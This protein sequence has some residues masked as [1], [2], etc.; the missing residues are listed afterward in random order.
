MILYLDLET[1]SEIPLKLGVHKYAEGVHAKVIVCAWAIDDGEVVV[2]D[3]LTGPR[4]SEAFR[5][6]W[7]AAD[8]IVAHN[9][10]FDRIMLKVE[11]FET[12]IERWRCTMAQAM[13]NSL[14]GSLDKLCVIMKVP[15]AQA[16][17]SGGKNLINL[18]CIPR[19]REDGTIYFFDGITHPTEWAE[20]LRYAGNDVE[21][22]RV[23]HKKLPRHNYRG[24]ELATW[25][26]DQKINDRGIS[27]D[28]DLSRAAIC[29]ADAEQKRLRA[30][31]ADA[32][33]GMLDSTTQRKEFLEHC[34][35]MYGVQL[36]DLQAGTLE[37]RLED[38]EIPEPVKELL[39]IRLMASKT[40]S[41][42]Y[43]TLT[44]AVCAD[45]RLHGL[46][47]FCGASRTGRWAGRLFQPQNLPRTPKHLSKQMDFVIDSI[48]D[49]TVDL[50]FEN[51]MEA[52]GAAT[53]GALCAAPGKKLVV[54][55][56]SNIEG[57]ML[58]WLA[59]EQWKLRAFG[60]FDEGT[61]HDLYVLAYSA[62]FGVH[63]DA[64]VEDEAA[65]GKMRLIGKVQELACQFGGA[66]GAFVSM[67]QAYGITVYDTP[68]PPPFAKG[69]CISKKEVLSFV[70]AWRR[71]NA[72]IVSFW[73]DLENAMI[74]AIQSPGVTIPVGRLHVRRDGPWLRI[75]LPSGRFLCYP[76]PEYS[77]Q[78][79]VC[80]S[81]GGMKLQVVG[82]D[83][84][85]PVLEECPKCKGRGW[86][87]DIVISYMGMHQYTRQWVRIHTFG[88]KVCENV[89]SAPSRD[90]LRDGMLDAEA[91]GYSVCLSVHDELI[92][93]TPDTDE[94]TAEGLAAIMTR[95]RAWCAGLPLAAKGYEALR[96]RK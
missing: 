69:V 51:T 1:R 33:A 8:E 5:Q 14:P 94:W 20:F 36:P 67:G 26:L 87:M 28:A 18:F 64:V 78:R 55:D 17:L 66:Y 15:V 43:K 25:H 50:F 79:V 12:D 95:P 45:G 92:T 35:G 44:N 81:C 85:G 53:R 90:V 91:E 58:A 96:Y 59:G 73:G 40:S 84:S 23:L 62:A 65:G 38:P 60:E 39:R 27:V 3:W 30:R 32:T 88:G 93:E 46:L 72:A 13:S 31:T 34:L 48:K 7:K 57:R 89:T 74:T 86:N 63:P 76:H 77:Q 22:C 2:E 80:R 75:R 9:A 19:K 54:A 41:T 42:K 61:G 83:E 68:E 82:E 52:L 10:Q 70:S 37:R 47:A 56:L 29:A 16:K 4:A 49:N 71:A 24:V 21:A 11:G 6:A